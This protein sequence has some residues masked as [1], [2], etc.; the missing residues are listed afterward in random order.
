MLLSRLWIIVIGIFAFVWVDGRVKYLGVVVGV[1]WVLILGWSRVDCGGSIALAGCVIAVW[2]I[3]IVYKVL[4]VT[5]RLIVVDGRHR[6]GLRLLLLMAAVRPGGKAVLDLDTVPRTHRLA[7]CAIVGA[8]TA[9]G[10]VTGSGSGSSHHGVDAI[11]S[12][13]EGRD[14][15]RRSRV[16]RGWGHGG[17]AG[18][19]LQLC[20]RLL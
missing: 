9:R 6:R 11:D 4:G 13:L 5:S 14:Y 19:S 1:V 18:G 20:L 12:V 16:D 8:A 15:K 17:E 10:I 3:V 7:V 2:I